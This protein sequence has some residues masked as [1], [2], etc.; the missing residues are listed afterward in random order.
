MKVPRL[1]KRKKAGLTDYRKRL[2]LLKSGT[3]R[4]VIRPSNKGFTAQI[5]EYEAGGD[6]IISTVKDRSLAKLGV[7][8][9]G[10]STPVA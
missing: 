5:V 2:G 7:E 9:K 10:N 8:I 3:P 4:L 1:V 6:R